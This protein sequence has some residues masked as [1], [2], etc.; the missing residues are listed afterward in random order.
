VQSFQ[1]PENCRCTKGARCE[2][3][4]VDKGVIPPPPAKKEAKDAD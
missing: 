1:R 3:C 4:L 2:P